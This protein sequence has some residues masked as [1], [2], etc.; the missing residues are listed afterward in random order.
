MF[1]SDKDPTSFLVRLPAHEKVGQEASRQGT[2]QVTVQVTVQDTDQ[3]TD[4]DTVQVTDQVEQLVTV[5]SGEMG[6]AQLQAVLGLA[7]RRHFTTAYLKPALAAGL[8][9]MTLPDKPTSRHQRY[10]RTAAG[11]ALAD[12]TKGKGVPA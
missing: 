12:R 7:H 3:D 2:S 9:E 10:R 4:Q 11:Q 1:E 8:I 5:L 6:R